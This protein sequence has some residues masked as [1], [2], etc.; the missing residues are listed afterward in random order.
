MDIY[1]LNRVIQNSEAKHT[2]SSFA[3]TLAFSIC[4]LLIL[5]LDLVGMEE[6]RA[7]PAERGWSSGDY[8]G[9][10]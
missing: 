4:C 6:E 1:Q 7:M 2:R 5:S 9:T 8:L 3:C 10:C